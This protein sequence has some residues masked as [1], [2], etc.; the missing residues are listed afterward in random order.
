MVLNKLSGIN[1]F[2]LTSLSLGRVGLVTGA[3]TQRLQQRRFLNS[4]A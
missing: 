2:P 3:G 4:N 1:V